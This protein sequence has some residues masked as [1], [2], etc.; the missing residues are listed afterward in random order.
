MTPSGSARAPE[1][2]AREKI[3][4]ALAAAGWTLQ[5]RDE[6]NVTPPAVAVRE[7]RLE[8]GRGYVDYLLF[9]D[10]KPVGVCEA[11]P[12]GFLVRNVEVHAFRYVD[13]LPEVLEAPFKPLPFAYISTGE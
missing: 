6:M 11:K 4:A 8:R 2:L 9:V 10:G 1:A 13:G 3:D 5:Y 7:F 12:A